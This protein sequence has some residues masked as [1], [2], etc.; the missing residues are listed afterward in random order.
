[1]I[2][3]KKNPYIKR[4]V[5]LTV[6]FTGL[7]VSYIDAK[8]TC[9]EC[10][11]D[12]KLRSQNKILSDY[13][14]NWKDSTHEIADVT[15]RDCHGGDPAKTDKEEAHKDDFSSLT[16]VNKTSFKM[17]PKRCGKCHEA[18]LKNF[19]ESEHY[20]ALIEKGAGPHCA[21]CHGSVNV[22]VY[23]TSVIARSCKECHNEYT[24]NR[25]EIVG[26]ADK[27]LHRI[28]VSHAFKRWVLIE[29]HEEYA[30]EVEEI[31]ALYRY[32]AESW[33]KFDFAELDQ[34]SLDLLNKIKS[35]VNRGLEAKKKETEKK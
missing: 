31:L 9:V 16:S 12:I 5:F 21:T 3:V 29:Y 4:L 22:S 20:K 35:L 23:Y 24:N 19:L 17:I 1:M 13:Y 18:V 28:N 10:H 6:F 14:T 15:C 7:F 30:A 34:K 2:F 27:I 11:R 32:V 25:P 8:G 26:E 33:H